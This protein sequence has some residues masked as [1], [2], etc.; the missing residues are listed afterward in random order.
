M[1]KAGILSITKTPHYGLT[2][3]MPIKIV[4]EIRWKSCRSWDDLQKKFNQTSYMWNKKHK[5]LCNKKLGNKNVMITGFCSFGD[6]KKRDELY[7][8]FPTFE[9]AENVFFVENNDDFVINL[10]KERKCFPDNANVYVVD[11]G[12]GHG[13]KFYPCIAIK[14]KI[15]EL[16]KPLYT[17][18]DIDNMNHRHFVT[19]ESIIDTINEGYYEE[20]AIYK[21]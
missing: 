17:Q 14:C 20:N 2:R 15:N 1:S 21:E 5:A 9:D 18:R 8:N 7:H 11:V 10:V 19:T 6:T 4:K 16:Q 13:V 3:D 12:I